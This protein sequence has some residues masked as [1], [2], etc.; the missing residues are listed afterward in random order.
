MRYDHRLSRSDREGVSKL[1]IETGGNLLG[2]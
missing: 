2:L 1:A